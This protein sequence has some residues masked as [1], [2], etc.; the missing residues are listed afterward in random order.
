LIIRQVE[1]ALAQLK[2]VIDHQGALQN[3]VSV[4]P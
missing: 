1:N 3:S 2:P 4:I